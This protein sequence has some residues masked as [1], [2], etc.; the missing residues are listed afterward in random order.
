MA[1]ASYT[2]VCAAT[3]LAACKAYLKQRQEEIDKKV[4]KLVQCEMNRRFF[5]AKTREDALARRAE[6][7][8]WIH[9]TGSYWA[10]KVSDLKDLARLSATGTVRLSADD[11][12]IILKYV[13]NQKSVNTQVD[14]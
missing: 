3:V 9:I 7:I 2:D 13:D 6:S 4:E 8:D 14:G 10:G 1:N 11:A 5:P 12:S